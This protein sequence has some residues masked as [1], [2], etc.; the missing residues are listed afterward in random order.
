[1]FGAT[2][3]EQYI[4]QLTNHTYDQKGFLKKDNVPKR[5]TLPDT[6]W[7]QQ[8]VSYGLR[9]GIYIP[10]YD[11]LTRSNVMGSYF[12]HIPDTI[13]ENINLMSGNILT[14]LMCYDIFT[15]PITLAD[16]QS[17][18]CGYLALYNIMRQVHP[19]L[20]D[21]P[22]LYIK[23]KCKNIDHLGDYI[24]KWKHFLI[25]EQVCQRQWTPHDYTHQ[26]I[27]G[28]PDQ[29]IF[30]VNNEFRYSQQRENHTGIPTNFYLG[31][32]AQTIK[33][34]RVWYA[35]PRLGSSS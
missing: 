4:R 35:W 16:I 2:T 20:M 1:M 7:Y 3:P 34:Y 30:W 28:L 9:H 25:Q 13:K 6:I 12:V 23:P 22:P 21:R 19:M 26:L 32:I 18:D 5:G 31:T 17:S 10:P 14:S 33:T 27:H 15:N 29:F 24:N 8:Y 11:S